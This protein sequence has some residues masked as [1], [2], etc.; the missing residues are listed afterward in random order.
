MAI[1]NVEEL[2]LGPSNTN[3]SCD[4]KEDLNPGPSEYKS[5]TLFTRPR[6]LHKLAIHAEYLLG[7]TARS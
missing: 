4:R 5:N 2:N 1:T 3:S 6:C 7:A